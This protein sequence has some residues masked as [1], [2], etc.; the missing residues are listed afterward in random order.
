MKNELA[1]FQQRLSKCEE[2]IMNLPISLVENS[3]IIVRIDEK[4]QSLVRE[5]ADLKQMITGNYIR[6]EEFDPVKKSVAQQT[7]MIYGIVAVVLS[8]IVAGIS[9]FF[10]K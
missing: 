5:V 10:T 2:S 8:A 3:P 7:A 9:A 4:V 6:R 1:S